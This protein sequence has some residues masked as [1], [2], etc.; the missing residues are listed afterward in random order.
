MAVAQSNK[1]A[2]LSYGYVRR[3]LNK[4][5]VTTK[6]KGKQKLSGA[7]VCPGRRAAPLS[8]AGQADPFGFT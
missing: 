2:T 5:L 8:R 1:T 6:N 3:E 7:G 4:A